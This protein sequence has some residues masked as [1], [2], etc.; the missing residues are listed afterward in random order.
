[1]AED[2]D[3]GDCFPKKKSGEETLL[4]PDRTLTVTPE[5]RQQ[6]QHKSSSKIRRAWATTITCSAKAA[7]NIDATVGG[8]SYFLFALGFAEYRA[9][10]IWDAALYFFVAVVLVLVKHKLP[11]GDLTEW[12]RKPAPEKIVQAVQKAKETLTGR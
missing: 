8:L 3:F 4:D 12:L 10:H 2:V 9:G 1:M 7:E 11:D 5:Q 6:Q